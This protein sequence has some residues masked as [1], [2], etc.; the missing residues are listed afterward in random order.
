[1]PLLLVGSYTDHTGGRGAG[2]TT[3]ALDAA[4]GAMSTVAQ[5][6]ARSP[7]YLAAH[8]LLPVW[9]ALNELNRGAVSV[10][11]GAASGVPAV[12]DEHDSG[13]SGPCHLAVTDDGR[14]LVC[15]HYGDGSIAVFRL[16]ADGAIAGRADLVVHSGHGP[17]PRRQESPHVH[18]AVPEPGGDL[19]HA[20]DLGTDE[21]RTYRLR[22]DGRLEHAATTPLPPGSGPRQLLRLPDPAGEP[23]GTAR[24]L[25]ACELSSQVLLVTGVPG[26][27]LRV[28][29]S[30]AATGAR[31]ADGV[32]NY[33]AHLAVA[34][35][36]RT[37]LLS[38]RGADCLTAF[39]IDGDSLALRA[40]YPTG[41]GP[42]H[43]CVTGS[44]VVVADTADDRLVSFVLEPDG[45]ARD[46]G[47]RLTLGSPAC[48]LPT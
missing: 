8:P 1:M 37:V 30:A 19:V 48:V 14:F 33:P 24:Y 36:G 11:T 5:V 7:S 3:V 39:T 28:M 43:F 2:L 17:D 40:E 29:S 42:R 41:A 10:L 38:N 16:A 15:A 6:E 45:T 27:Q 9:Y 26:Q 25:V 18:M 13:G 20:V 32:R 23:P 34:P 44:A 4:T 31:L 12:V 21:V 46:T 22:S 35:H 47:H